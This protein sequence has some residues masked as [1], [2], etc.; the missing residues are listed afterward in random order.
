MRFKSSLEM[1]TAY[2][3]TCSSKDEGV[4]ESERLLALLGLG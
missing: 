3:R 2:L 1:A 4:R